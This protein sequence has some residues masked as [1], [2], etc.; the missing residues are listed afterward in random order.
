MKIIVEIPT[1][2][3]TEEVNQNLYSQTFSIYLP[4]R[5]LLDITH[6][7]EE[8][9]QGQEEQLYINLCNGAWELR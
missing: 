3:L 9:S 2:K 8:A 5:T 6:A 7:L 4:K 1:G